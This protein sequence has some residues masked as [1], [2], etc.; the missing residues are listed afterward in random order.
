MLLSFLKTTNMRLLL[1]YHKS[2]KKASKI[3]DL[4]RQKKKKTNNI[5]LAF[6]QSI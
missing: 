3:Y 1:S 5:H 4:Q 6:L 2:E